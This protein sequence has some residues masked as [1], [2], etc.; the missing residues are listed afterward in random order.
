[1]SPVVVEDQAAKTVCFPS[2]MWYDFWNDAL[3]EGPGY[4][5]V[6]T[7]LD[8]MPLFV[9]AGSIIPMWPLVQSTAD[10]P[11]DTLALAVYPSISGGRFE[12]YEDD[13]HTLQ[14][15]QGDYALTEF[16]SEL[17]PYGEA[18]TL[19]LDI[20]RTQGSYQGQASRRT[21][22]ATV[23]GVLTPPRCVRRDGIELPREPSYEDLRTGN[24]GWAFDSAGLLHVRCDLATDRSCRIEAESLSVAIGSQ[25]PMPQEFSLEQNYPNPFVQ[26]TRIRFVMPVSG[27]VQLALY[28][29]SGRELVTLLDESR[30]AGTH[31][32]E[33]DLDSLD[34]SLP[35]AGFAFCR[36][37][38]EGSPD[39]SGS[40]S[41]RC[42]LTRPII[43]LP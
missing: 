41:T 36:L 16:T 4:L 26:T 21:Y 18:T 15:Q 14:Y 20:G 27:Q 33:V 8:I 28:D 2:G 13:G 38:V 25:M 10:R 23:H 1:M 43:R 37:E 17:R 19:L 32:I 29:A 6:A 12:M 24:E 42:S 7:P 22:L 39:S 3:Q 9:R 35:S 30:P 11:L 31:E 40:R 34:V 5:S